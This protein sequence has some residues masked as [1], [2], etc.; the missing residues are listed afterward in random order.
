LFKGAGA[1]L[2]SNK[3]GWQLYAGWQTGNTGNRCIRRCPTHSHHENCTRESMPFYWDEWKVP[4]SACQNWSLIC[5]DLWRLSSR[6]CVR[7]FM[8]GDAFW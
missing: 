1:I 3:V 6:S 4:V 5:S 2:L 8:K 7:Q